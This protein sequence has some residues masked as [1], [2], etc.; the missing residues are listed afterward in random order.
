MSTD[1]V[2]L[3]DVTDAL[4]SDKLLSADDAAWFF[5]NRSDLQPWYI[6][7]MVGFGAW[8]ASLLLIG[9]VAS[10]SVAIDGGYAFIGLSLI[11][12]AVLIRHRTENDFL[13][14]CALASSLAGQALLGYGF[15]ETVGHD[16]FE[17]FL[18]FALVVSS[19]LFFVPRLHP[20]RLNGTPWGRRID[21]AVVCLGGEF[22]CPAPRAGILRC[23][24]PPAPADAEPDLEQVL[25]ACASADERTDAERLW[26]AAAL[27]GLRPPG[28]RSGRL[29]LSPTLGIDDPSWWPTPL[30]QHGD[31]IHGFGR[32]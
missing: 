1:K 6:R 3:R 29:V 22:A 11:V 14:Q 30:C 28:A 7:T 25:S 31:S 21:Y 17:I 12:V 19:V 9:F 4:Q 32:P 16:E 23:L 2:T 13:I 27:Y 26:C 15:A 8:L 5:E 20:P 18:G 24:Y 10:F